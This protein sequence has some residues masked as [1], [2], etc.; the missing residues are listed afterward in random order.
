[1]PQHLELRVSWFD[2][3]E[4]DDSWLDEAELQLQC[5]EA[6]FAFWASHGGRSQT[7]DVD[8]DVDEFRILRIV[9]CKPKSNRKRGSGKGSKKAVDKKK[10]QFLVEWV[11]YPKETWEPYGNLPDDMVEQFLDSEEAEGGRD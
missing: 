7:L 9:D 6:V 1:M 4:S 5:P 2:Y 11:G 10:Q 3:D 8:E